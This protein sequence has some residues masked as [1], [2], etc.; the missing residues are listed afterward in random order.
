[1]TS[2]DWERVEAVM[3]GG[4]WYSAINPQI[5]G[6]QV[7]FKDAQY[8]DVIVNLSAIDGVRFVRRSLAKERVINT[9]WERK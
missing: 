6:G 4:K 2:I 7:S 3:I 8:R 9:P 1:M 5:C